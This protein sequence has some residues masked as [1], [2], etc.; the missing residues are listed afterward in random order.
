[1]DCVRSSPRAATR[2][3]TR[4]RLLVTNDDDLLWRVDAARGFLP[5]SEESSSSHEVLDVV[6][7]L[8]REIPCSCATRGLFR[9]YVDAE[10]VIR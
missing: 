4:G 6:A 10:A 7:R 5:S 9:S 2:P 8:A 3:P 1:M